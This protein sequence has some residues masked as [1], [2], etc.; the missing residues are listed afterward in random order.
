MSFDP[1]DPKWRTI[2]GFSR[3][4]L[5]IT[6]YSTRLFTFASPERLAVEFDRGDLVAGM[7][8]WSDPNDPEDTVII[9]TTPP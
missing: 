5:S 8:R 6:V 2:K 9:V 4:G 3:P 7:H 1:Q